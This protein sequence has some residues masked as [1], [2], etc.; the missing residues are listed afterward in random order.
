MAVRGSAIIGKADSGESTQITVD[1]EGNLYEA[2]NIHTFADRAR[3]AA[4]RQSVLYPTRARRTVPRIELR[5]VGWFDSQTGITLLENEQARDA[6]A[7][8]LDVQMVEEKELRF[9]N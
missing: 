3:H 7:S 8:W 1:F 4:G 9:S 6:L 5:Q 2:A